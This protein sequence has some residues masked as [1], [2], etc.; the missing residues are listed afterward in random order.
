MNTAV[1]TLWT[2]SRYVL[3]LVLDLVYK[4]KVYES[5]TRLKALKLYWKE[6]ICLALQ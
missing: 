1:N 2:V 5:Q 6:H 3:S 4:D